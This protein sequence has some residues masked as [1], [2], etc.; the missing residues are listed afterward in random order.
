MFKP[1]IRLRSVQQFG[2]LSSVDST[3]NESIQLSY[4]LGWFYYIHLTE[5]GAFKEGHGDGF[6]HYSIIFPKQGTGI[7]IMS[8][9][10]NAESIFKE[11]LEAT[12]GEYLHSLVLGKLYSIQSEEK[13]R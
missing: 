4:G 13:L 10:D 3:T 6:Q 9:S 7:I 12:I 8:N 1:Q 5:T 2:P 11:L